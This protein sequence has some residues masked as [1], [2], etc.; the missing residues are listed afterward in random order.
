MEDWFGEGLGIDY[1]EFVQTQG[2]GLPMVKLECEFLSPKDTLK[3]SP[4]KVCMA[5][6]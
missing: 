6:S 1:A 4:V 5:L 2:R 3:Y